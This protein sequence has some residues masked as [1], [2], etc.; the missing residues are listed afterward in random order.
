M[1]C[2]PLT[3]QRSTCAAITATAVMLAASDFLKIGPQC[4]PGPA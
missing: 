4:D 1:T 3:V 2:S